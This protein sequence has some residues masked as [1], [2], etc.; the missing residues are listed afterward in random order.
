MCRGLS[1]I[2]R[3]SPAAICGAIPP[4]RLRIGETI[5]TV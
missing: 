5:H 3:P 4:I 1:L 2:N